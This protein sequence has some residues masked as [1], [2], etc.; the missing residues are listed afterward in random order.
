MSANVAQSILIDEL[1]QAG[2]ISK[3][4][5]LRESITRFVPKEFLHIE[6]Y[7][8]CDKIDQFIAGLN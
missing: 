6:D 1:I 5:T 3:L 4:R 8:N 7:E 2:Q